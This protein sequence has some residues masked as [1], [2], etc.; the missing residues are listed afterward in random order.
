MHLIITLHLHTSLRSQ[1]V[2]LESHTSPLA[3]LGDERINKV[4]LVHVA[5]G[6]F[7]AGHQTKQQY[8]SCSYRRS[9]CCRSNVGPRVALSLLTLGELGVAALH[10]FQ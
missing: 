10:H 6:V 3:C 8:V 1:L 9:D 5:E 2:N 7:H 4:R